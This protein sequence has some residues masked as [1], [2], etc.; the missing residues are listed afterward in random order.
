[1]MLPATT[2]L[3]KE[4]CRNYIEEYLFGAASSSSIRPENE[5]GSVGVELEC[6]P[7]LLNAQNEKLPV[8][9]YGSIHPLSEVLFHFS[10]LKGGEVQNCNKESSGT[11]NKHNIDAINFPDGSS[12]NF[13]PGAQVEIST[14]PCARFEDVCSKVEFMQQILHKISQQTS[15]RFLQCGTH[16]WFTTSQIGMQLD[17][18]RYRAMARYFDKQNVF[19]RKMMVQTCSLQVNID[20]GND[21]GVRA[22]R[23]VAANLLAPF[24]TALFAHSPVAAGKVNGY[25]S[26]RSYIWQQLDKARTGIITTSQVTNP[27]D[28]NAIVDAYLHFALKAPVIYIEDFDDEIFPADITLDYWIT[29]SI[30]GKRPTLSHFRNHLTLLFPEVRLKGYL[31]LRSV[32]APPPEWQMVPVLFYCGLLY[33]DSYLDKVLDLLLPWQSELP[34]LREQA[35]FGLKPEAIFKIAKKLMPL[36]IEGFST[37]PEY[38][39]SSNAIRQ[40]IAFS[41]KFTLQRKTFA[42]DFLDTFTKKK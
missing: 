40:A 14:A 35:V 38:F 29:H 32:D 13:E 19:G 41:E 5:V 31:E 4:I 37:L 30:K 22:K 20:S 34:L 11:T 7:Y 24:A 16:P 27:F 39:K 2:I 25:Q 26:Y 1:M 33:S 17:K 8:N 28:K 23:F 18:P 36:A 15:F 6:F 21:W 3:S 10:S 42:D 9:L 12:F